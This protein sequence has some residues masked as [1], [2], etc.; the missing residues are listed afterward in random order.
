MT[1]EEKLASLIRDPFKGKGGFMPAKIK[2]KVTVR[3]GLNENLAFPEE[4]IKRLI[5]QVAK[6]ID[7]RIY[8]EDYCKSLCEVIAQ[9]NQINAN[10]VV[11]GNG[12]DKIIDLMVRLTIK[13]GSSA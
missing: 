5:L 1:K 9:D 6:T 13:A 11:I 2:E 10:Q 7:P 4:L 3:A 12:G 8:P